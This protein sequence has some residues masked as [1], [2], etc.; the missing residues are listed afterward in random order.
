MYHWIIGIDEVGRG[1]LAGPVVVGAVLVPADFD[2]AL[3]PGVT[4]SKKLSEKK[5][6][7]IYKQALALAA[8]G[9]LWFAVAEESA[10]TIDRIGI[11]PSIRCALAQALAQVLEA[12][13]KNPPRAALG[14]HVLGVPLGPEMV[15]VLLDGGLRAPA[16]FIHQ[17][18]IIKGDATEPVIG[19]ASIMAKVT[20]DRT[21][22]T[23]AELYPSYGLEQHK[24]YGTAQHRQ[25]I[26]KLGL[27]AIHRGTFCRGL[28]M[29]EGVV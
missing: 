15:R 23:L 19:L 17:E 13:N 1:P 18:T 24:G 14:S 6:E 9:K 26:A 7:V 12:A 22:V 5:R 21:M 20:R 25:T 29:S 4:D 16:E 11:A 27:S 3:L 2:W 10:Q 28:P 8:S